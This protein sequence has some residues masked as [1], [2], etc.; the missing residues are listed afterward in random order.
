M[1]NG[2]LAGLPAP[3]PITFA[4][5]RQADQLLKRVG[6]RLFGVGHPHKAMEIGRH[7]R[8]ILDRT[9]VAWQSEEELAAQAEAIKPSCGMSVLSI[10]TTS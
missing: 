8:S 4:T 6:D 7:R 10:S 5:Q 2:R 9:T 3:F 1:P